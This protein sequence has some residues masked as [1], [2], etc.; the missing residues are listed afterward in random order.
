MFVTSLKLCL[1]FAVA[2][3]VVRASAESPPLEEPRGVT[4]R[5][6]GEI[7][8]IDPR[9][10]A[11]VDL[12]API[13]V[14]AEGFDWS[15]GPVWIAEHDYVVFS[16]VP[17]NTVYRWAE[18]DGLSVWLKPSGFTGTTARGG[19]MGSNG[20]TLDPQ[21]RLLLC[22]HGDRRV[23]RLE[24]SL[25]PA[26]P[27]RQVVYADLAARFEGRRFNS[28][29][30]LAVHPSGA[31]YFTDPAYG[32]PAGFGDP[33]REIDFVGVYRVGTD[34]ELSVLDKTLAAPNGVA[35]SPDAKTLY[36]AQSDGQAPAIFAYEVMED[37]SVENR[38]V[39]F[40]AK[41]LA[42]RGL[43]G[44]PDGLRVDLHGNLFATG[45]GGVLVLSPTGE[46]LGTIHT[47]E[48]IANCCFGGPD[49]RTLYMTS[50]GLLCRVQLKTTGMGFAAAE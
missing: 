49:G 10:D 9:L 2:L 19:E 36:V 20:L 6:V 43:Q 24:G 16:D 47:G 21:G 25:P 27:V 3:G 39:L 38:R 18:G 45:P 28:P 4:G 12:Q 30:D 34:G 26:G 29:N 37:G 44:S 33:N 32:M 5:T 7:E 13:E 50:D 14:L 22:Q 46:H 31:V 8:R 40:D 48:R 23:A 42:D 35:L 17:R 11:L 41:P 1:T 15:E